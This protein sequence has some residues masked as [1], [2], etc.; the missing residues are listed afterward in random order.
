M[1]LRPITFPVTK[2]CLE[3][4][5]LCVVHTFR[6]GARLSLSKRAF[7]DAA[8]LHT[9]VSALSKRQATTHTWP[10]STCTGGSCH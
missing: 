8:W 6:R 2:F 10:L 7:C 3:Q 5:K 4:F 9:C 1:N